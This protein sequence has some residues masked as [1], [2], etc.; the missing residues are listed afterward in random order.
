MHA[1]ALPPPIVAA[2]P[3]PARVEGGGG[4]GGTGPGPSLHWTR[5]RPAPEPG[6]RVVRPKA[7]N[8]CRLH[9]QCGWL[10][11]SS[12]L[13]SHAKDSCA[14]LRFFHNEEKR[15]GRM[16][17]RIYRAASGAAEYRS[18]R[19]HCIVRCRVLEARDPCRAEDPLLSFHK[20]QSPPPE[21]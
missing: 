19:D 20:T 11:T 16:M 3:P 5:L 14:A 17:A 6:T 15:K 2:A 13:T 10:G 4:V 8:P 7:L 1:Y 12:P 21:S 18:H 9:S